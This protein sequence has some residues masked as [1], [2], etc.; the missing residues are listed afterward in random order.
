MAR[1]NEN[2]ALSSELSIE[3]KKRLLLELKLKGKTPPP[4]ASESSIVKRPPDAPV[5]ISSGERSLWTAHSVSDHPAA[6][7]L[8]S[9]YHVK[10]TL[11][12]HYLQS[13]LQATIDQHENLRSSYSYENSQ[14]VKRIEPNPT[15]QLELSQCDKSQNLRANAKQVAKTPF[16]LTKAP[17]LRLTLISQNDRDHVLVFSIHHI[18]C[19]EWSVRLF[20]ET[21]SRHYNGLCSGKP[22]FEKEPTYTYSDYLYCK[23]AKPNPDLQTRNLAFWQREL[24]ALPSP[25]TLTNRPHPPTASQ[26]GAL[27]QSELPQSL[28]SKVER[29][30]SDQHATPFSTYLLAFYGL[31]RGQTGQKD[32]VIATP[33]A[34]R[35]SKDAESLIGYFLN[36][37]PVRLELDEEIPI[38]ESLEAVQSKFLEAAEHQHIPIEALLEIAR[39]NGRTGRHPLYHAMFVF[40][41]ETTKSDSLDLAD[42]ETTPVLVDTDSSKFGI[43][44]F[45]KRRRDGTTILI[46]YRTD[47]FDAADIEAITERYIDLIGQL[48]EQPNAPLRSLFKCP[49]PALPLPESGPPLEPSNKNSVLEFLANLPVDPQ[50]LA[51]QS[52]L[53]Y[54]TYAELTRDTDQ[55]AKVLLA[56]GAAAGD[57]IAVWGNR[58]ARTVLA[59]V[60][61]LKAG[62]TYLA[63]DPKNPIERIQDMMTD[64]GATLLIAPEEAP[65]FDSRTSFKIQMLADLLEY[66]SDTQAIALPEINSD[67]IAYLIYTSG[68]TGR[69]KAVEVTHGNLLYSTRARM[70]YYDRDPGRFL[71]LP[72]FAF[73]SSVAGLFWTISTGGTLFIPDSIEALDP[74]RLTQFVSV[75]QIQTSLC[76]PTLYRHMLDWGTTKL[77]SMKTMIVAGE[78]CPVSVVN[79]HLKT[80]PDCELFNEYGPS[81]ATVWASV[82]KFA[83]GDINIAPIGRPIPG[84]II[85]ILDDKGERVPA[86][87]IGELHIGGPGV[88][89]GY[90]NQKS[91]AESRFVTTADGT[92]LYASG[93]FAKW[94][95]DGELIYRGRNDEQVK[96]RGHRIELSEIERHLENIPGV[97]AAAVVL[98]KSDPE[99]SPSESTLESLIN[100]LPESL[101][102][103]ALD[104]IEQSTRKHRYIKRREEDEFEVAI[105]LKSNDFVTP[106]R[107]AQKDWL[108]GQ[109]I[110]ETAEDLKHLDKVSRTFVKGKDHQLNEGVRD[111]SHERL[112]EREFMEEWQRP[113]MAEMA[114]FVAEQRGDV[115]E[116]GYGRG[117]SAEYIQTHTPRS[118]T[119]IE[120]N[121]SS[122][123]QH[124]ELWRKRFPESKIS[125]H[126]ARWQDVLPKL[127]KF[128][129]ILFHT[130]PMNEQEFVDYILNSITFAEHAFADMA[131][132]LKPGG[133]FTYLT[134]E[135]DSLSRRH[136]RALFQHFSEITSKVV[137]VS[138]L[139]DTIDSWWSQSMV[140]L[141][142][143]K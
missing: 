84:S 8:I 96:I 113:L 81:E 45:V 63:I 41:D 54:C 115:L 99:P 106:P 12:P 132:H 16:E 61:I 79:K 141:K 126:H 78:T 104:R 43:S 94:G 48:A 34:E 40:Q 75:H 103:E 4:D 6:Y 124:Y 134:T 102:A 11:D 77:S 90:R 66:R 140:V 76:V 128:D 123:E 108:I 35:Q 3:E 138:P 70:K 32:L 72:S 28:C 98:Q 36:T 137:P 53:Y 85:R 107:K 69:P 129:G 9:A 139:E 101:I 31:L 133:V 117:V 38:N 56:Q 89:R 2:L 92:R 42:C 109:L 57:T 68:S 116:I 114:R 100:E 65:A 131:S 5:P 52:Q 21:F 49:R 55:I 26:K 18:I 58:S 143:T 142:A 51:L 95:D 33:I 10:G 59:I 73:D 15:A 97:Q 50:K 111:L 22:V 47:L 14:L 13:A 87:E 25:L 125:M 30:L 127:G 88:S 91:L 130:Y 112:N 71:L 62:C 19:D 121:A 20:W 74:E 82:H 80:L 93:D 44:I 39:P 17:L 135:I 120:M 119:I 136:Q 83:K 67:Q 7:N 60:G 86:G 118:H 27:W 24:D 64:S 122:I 110:N 23:Y 37:L 105:N 46:E 1:P 29:L